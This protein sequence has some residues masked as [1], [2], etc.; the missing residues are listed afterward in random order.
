MV[1]SLAKDVPQLGYY[2]AVAHASLDEK[3]QAF[4]FLEQAYIERSPLLFS[5][6]FDLRLDNLR[7]DPR[8][9]YLVRRMGLEL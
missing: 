4:T 3:E 7:S 5:L 1:Q 9:A 6:R 2:M 8:Y